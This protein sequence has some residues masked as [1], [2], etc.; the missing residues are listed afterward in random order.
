MGESAAAGSVPRLFARTW[1][2]P[3]AGRPDPATL[4]DLVEVLIPQI[5]ELDGYQGG[6]LMVDRD[7][8]DIIATTF[9]DSLE[10]LDAGGDRAT[11]AAVGTLVVSAASSMH[12]GV[13]DVLFSDGVPRLGSTTTRTGNS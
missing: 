12:V 1:R 6:A 3:G 5:A 10:H 13:C 9:W 11:N 4:R 8:G 2:L 7:S